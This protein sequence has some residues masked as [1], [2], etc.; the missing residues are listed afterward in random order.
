MTGDQGR[1]QVEERADAISGGGVGGRK[2]RD[3]GEMW[4]IAAPI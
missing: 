3:A 2:K 4:Q 1:K